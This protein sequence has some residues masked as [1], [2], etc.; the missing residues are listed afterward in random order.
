MS[1]RHGFDFNND[2]NISFTESHMT[3]HIERETA[4]KNS[5]NRSSRLNIDNNT[6]QNKDSNSD[7]GSVKEILFYL[8]ITAASIGF[9]YL[10]GSLFIL[11][12][13]GH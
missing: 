9:M 3:Y 10:M 11:I 2:G 8:A 6:K 1:D 4:S 7:Y 5:G 12:N 13:G